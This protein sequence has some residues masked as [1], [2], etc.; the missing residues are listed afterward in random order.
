MRRLYLLILSFLLPLFSFADE[1]MWVPIYLQKYAIKQMQ[2]LGCKLS[3]DD[4]YSTDKP[5]LKDAIV[6]FG[7]GCTGE[8][9][10]SQGLVLTNYHCGYGSIQ[11]L[12]SLE[13][14]YLTDGFWAYDKSEELPVPGLT[15][16]F[17]YI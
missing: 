6:I 8:L 4:I 9:I 15:V 12:S 5:S 7:G 10:S 13:H 2:K 17:W 1:G 14:D 16:T 11:K 3:A